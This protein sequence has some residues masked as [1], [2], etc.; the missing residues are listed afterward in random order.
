LQAILS[1]AGANPMDLSSK[2]DIVAEIFDD[3]PGTNAASNFASINATSAAISTGAGRCPMP[4]SST[5][6]MIFRSSLSRRLLSCR[7][8]F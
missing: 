2:P 7:A 5:A 6:F 4:R 1:Y 8:M 3:R